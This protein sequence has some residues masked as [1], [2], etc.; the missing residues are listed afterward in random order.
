MHGL[1]QLSPKS[2]ATPVYAEQDALDRRC[3]IQKHLDIPWDVGRFAKFPALNPTGRDWCRRE[4]HGNRVRYRSK[5]QNRVR[6]IARIEPSWIIP[7]R[8]VH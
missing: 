2:L 4:S 1:R 7:L 8:K 6:T 5:V 3:R